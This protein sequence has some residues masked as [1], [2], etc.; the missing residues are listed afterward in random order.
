MELMAVLAN[1]APAEAS[2]R[3]L[4]SYRSGFEGGSVVVGRPSVAAGRFEGA[5]N[6]GPYAAQW[7]SWRRLVPMHSNSIGMSP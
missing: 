1:P 7:Q 6:R 2:W 5:V 4:Y 3:V